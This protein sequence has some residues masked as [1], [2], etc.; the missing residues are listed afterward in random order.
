M[1][2]PLLYLHCN[3]QVTGE[4]KWKYEYRTFGVRALLNVPVTI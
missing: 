2:A 4:S 1:K 3:S